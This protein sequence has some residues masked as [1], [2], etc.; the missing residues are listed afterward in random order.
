[1]SN[2]AEEWYVVRPE[3]PDEPCILTTEKPHPNQTAWGPFPSQGDAIA[4]RVGLIRSG[5][6]TPQ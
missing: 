5:K 4:A 6:C 1:M 2:T 3:N